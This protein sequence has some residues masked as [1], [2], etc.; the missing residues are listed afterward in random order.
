MHWKPFL[1][2]LENVFGLGYAV[3]RGEAPQKPRPPTCGS[4]ICQAGTRPC[5][6][7]AHIRAHM[8]KMTRF[9]FH[10]GHPPAVFHPFPPDHGFRVRWTDTGTGG[11]E[12]GQNLLRGHGLRRTAAFGG[13]KVA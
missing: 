4:G 2:V 7:R 9:P 5:A 6:V 11:W 1:S 13:V 3:A 8:I 10:L 12:L